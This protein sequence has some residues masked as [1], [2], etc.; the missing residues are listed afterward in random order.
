MTIFGF[1]KDIASILLLLGAGQGIFF[2]FVLLGI[3]NNQRRAYFWL[4]SFLILFSISMVGTVL[5][6][7]Q[8]VVRF[9]H[10][11]LITAPMGIA[12]GFMLYLYTKTLTEKKYRFTGWQYLHLLP[13]GISIGIL[14][15]F[16]L[17]PLEEKRMV[18]KN[19][20]DGYPLLWK[21]NF[22]FSTIINSWYLV[23]TILRVTRHE[24]HIQQL[25]SN[26]EHKSLLWVKHFIYAGIGTFV[27]CIVFSLFDIAAAD[28]ISNVMFS[29]V[30][31]IMGY[32]AL[33]QPEIF[34][35][36][37]EQIVD[38]T[39]EPS[40][41]KL[42][43]KYSK[44]SLTEERA[45]VLLVQLDELF[46]KEK[47]FLEPELTLPQLSER[48][49]ITPHQVSQLLNQFKKQTFFDFVNGFRV[50]HFKVE[51]KKPENA[52]LSLLALAFDSGFNSKAA[53]NTVFKKLTGNTPSSFR[54]SSK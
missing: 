6:D 14:M 21:V 8:L 7:Q 19:S 54:D 10:L 35:G 41:V 45:K 20:Y 39:D 38:S 2:S 48:L 30:I 27:S 23:L 31:Y 37:S 34:S 17:L 13:V 42:P 44:S 36:L 49:G 33:K 53:F 12:L 15:P 25:F 28:T 11:G 29:F 26:T 4:A 16:Y 5:Y 47:I 46:Y 1:V 51:V 52:H 3:S 43:V 22:I 18:L 9:P 50:E 32:R 40:L 24:R